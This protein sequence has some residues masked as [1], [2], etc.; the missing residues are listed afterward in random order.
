MEKNVQYKNGYTLSY[1][2]NGDKNGAAL[3]IHHGLIASINDQSLF[4]RLSAKGV[5]LIAIA[6]PGYGRSSPY[7]MK[8][9]AEW[10]DIVSVLLDSLELAH[11][12]VLGISSGAPYSYALGCRFPDRVRNLFVLSGVPALYDEQVLSFWPYPVKKNAGIAEMQELAYELFFA[13]LSAEELHGDDVQDSMMNHCFGVAQDLRLRGVD[14]GF[15]LCDVKG[16]VYMRHSRYDDSIPV[17]T[18]EISA[19]LLADCQLEISEDT[20]HFS[21]EVLDD[22]IATTMSRLWQAPG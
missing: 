2:D 19:G 21:K 13:G 16:K 10:A 15:R 14:W 3:L 12:D 9:F 4:E 11:F 22:F 8:N 18:A 7:E 1:T 20:V 5:R 17:I 6:R